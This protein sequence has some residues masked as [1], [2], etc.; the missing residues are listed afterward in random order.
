MLYRC[1]ENKGPAAFAAGFV[2][3]GDPDQK[4]LENW[5]MLDAL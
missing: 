2:P 4:T 3:E 1:Q 5:S